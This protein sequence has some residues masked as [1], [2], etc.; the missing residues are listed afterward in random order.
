[1]DRLEDI[2][3]E[4]VQVVIE[5]VSDVMD[6]EWGARE[7]ERIVVNY[8]TLLGQ[9]DEATSAIAFSVARQKGAA[10]E[11]VDFRLS[12]AAE[13]GLERVRT[14]MYGQSGAYWT[15]CDLTI[16][17][18]GR[19]SFAYSYEVP[20]RLS[21]NVHDTRFDDYLERYLARKGG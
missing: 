12:D 14:V 4:T 6:G 7:W 17:R 20:Y 15:V 19:Y 9:P 10:C 8:E 11:I 21:G 5:S 1:M 16:E 18:D 2:Y 13:A 3:G